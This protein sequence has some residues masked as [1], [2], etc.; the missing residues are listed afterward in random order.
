MYSIP[1]DLTDPIMIISPIMTDFTNEISIYLEYR[2][3]FLEIFLVMIIIILILEHDCFRV[4]INLRY[5]LVAP[6]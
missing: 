3:H 5:L 1:Q 6:E 2:T 4:D